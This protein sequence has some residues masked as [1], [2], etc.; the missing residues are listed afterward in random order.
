MLST[1]NACDHTKLP[2]ISVSPRLNL[3]K[4]HTTDTHAYLD[5]LYVLQDTRCNKCSHDSSSI[6]GSCIEATLE[7]QKAQASSRQASLKY[8]VYR[9]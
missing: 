8:R 6:A 5:I 7:R 4:A 3:R 1:L 9:F 2:E